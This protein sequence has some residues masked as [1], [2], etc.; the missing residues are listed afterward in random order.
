[1]LVGLGPIALCLC[2]KHESIVL[3]AG[4]LMSSQSEGRGGWGDLWNGCITAKTF[5][6]VQGEIHWHHLHESLVNRISWQFREL[7]EFKSPRGKKVS[8][9]THLLVSGRVV[10]V[11]LE[12]WPGP[13]TDAAQESP[14][15]GMDSK[16]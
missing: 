4:S 16:V 11:T 15:S 8:D 2:L 3:K 9:L 13:Q 10:T 14:D 12:D 7:V 6:A 1:M 5:Q